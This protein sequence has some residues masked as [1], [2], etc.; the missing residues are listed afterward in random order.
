MKFNKRRHKKEVIEEDTEWAYSLELVT[1][2][3]LNMIKR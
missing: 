2:K 3:V 1:T